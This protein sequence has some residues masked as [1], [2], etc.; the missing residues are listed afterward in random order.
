VPGHAGDM[1]RLI[2]VYTQKKPYSITQKDKKNDDSR[3]KIKDKN[4]LHTSEV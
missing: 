1:G 2:L 3:K 4:L